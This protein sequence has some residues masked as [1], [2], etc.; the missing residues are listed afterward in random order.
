MWRGECAL[1]CY[2]R[3]GKVCL[4]ATCT[5]STFDGSLDLVKVFYHGI[6]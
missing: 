4:I 1:T 3:S 5:G 6:E 2:D